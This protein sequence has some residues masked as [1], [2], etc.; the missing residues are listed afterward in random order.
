[1]KNLS[2]HRFQH[3]NLILYPKVIRL[4]ILHDATNLA[5]EG[6]QKENELLRMEITILNAK[7]VNA[8]QA[9]DINKTIVINA[10]TEQNKIQIEY[11]KEIQ[12]LKAKIKELEV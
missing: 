7:L 1:M 11:G 5:L 2:H 9:V 8:Q 3:D 12:L 6:L 10:L 4:I